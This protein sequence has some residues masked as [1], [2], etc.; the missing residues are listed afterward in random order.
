MTIIYRSVKGSGLTNDEI[1]GNFRDLDTRVA[2]LQALLAN[3]TAPTNTALPAI[4]GTDV[5]GSTLTAS[6]G[7]WLGSPTTFAYRWKRG[8]AVITGA[9]SSTYTLTSPDVG[10]QIT[11]GVIATNGIG[12]S[13]EVNSAATPTITGPSVD[14]RPRYGAGVAN[15][16]V[17]APAALL[18][19]MTAIG[20]NGSTVV[21]SAG[22]GVTI[23]PGAGQ[24]GWMAFEATASASGVTFTDSL[25]TGGWQGA[26]SS[27]NNGADDGSSPNTSVVT[28][29]D[30]TTN[31]RFFRQDYAGAPD[32]FS[33]A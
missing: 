28:Y 2:A 24:Y 30:G 10:T 32:T 8:G 14:S 18:A 23:N 9:T 31:W 33:T 11:V 4:T 6:T 13:S 5:S 26:S 17:A 20:S 19:S 22:V 27:G 12:S 29:S 25:G 15:A 1:D 7:T 16:G 21:G 3:S